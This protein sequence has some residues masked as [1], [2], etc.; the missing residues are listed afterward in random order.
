MPLGIDHLVAPNQGPRDDGPIRV[1][2]NGCIHSTYMY[3]LY[4]IYINI[5]RIL[6]MYI[7]QN[8]NL[9]AENDENPPQTVG[10][11]VT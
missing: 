4:Y 11:W 1:K 8:Q 9:R 3:I 6:C 5:I 7:P 10:F 2:L